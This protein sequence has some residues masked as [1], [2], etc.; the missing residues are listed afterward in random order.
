MFLFSLA[1]FII[2]TCTEVQYKAFVCMLFSQKKRRY[3]IT[4]KPFTMKRFKI[5]AIVADPLL[6]LA[7]KESP[8]RASSCSATTIYKNVMLHE[9]LYDFYIHFPMLMVLYR[10]INCPLY[11]FTTNLLSWVP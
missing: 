1:Q 11:L 4:I 2:V 6:G 5:G 9:P 3:M 8:T 7:H 10:F